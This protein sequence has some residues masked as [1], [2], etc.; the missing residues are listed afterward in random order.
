MNDAKARMT[1]LLTGEVDNY[2]TETRYI[3]KSGE[4]LWVSITV[5]TIHD[6]KGKPMQYIAMS[7]D[8][9]ETR[10]LTEQLSHQASHDALTNLINRREFER[11]LERVLDTIKLDQSEHALCYMDLDQFKVVN[12]TCGHVAGDELLR[13]LSMVLQQKVRK[14][15]TLARLGGDEFGI[16]MEHCALDQA[17]RVVNSLQ[18]AV[19]D[20]QFSLEDRIFR[21]QPRSLAD[22]GVHV[23]PPS[24][25][26]LAQTQRLGVDCP[27]L[28]RKEIQGWRTD[29][30]TRRLTRP[31]HNI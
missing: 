20:F 31:V 7:R 29:R 10:R 6:D 23:G 11:R 1:A 28:R 12:D 5:S 16:L 13:Q 15:D 26:P 21:W 17:H 24:G 30:T 8:I 3:H 27:R 4:V 22:D 18:Q 14:R 25:G 2:L 19:Q 9:T